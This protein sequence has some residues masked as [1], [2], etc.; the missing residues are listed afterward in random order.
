M[1]KIVALIAALLLCTGLAVVATSAA[2]PAK[3][4]A[5]DSNV[6]SP[7]HL[8]VNGNDLDAHDGEV[9][10][11]PASGLYYLFGTSYGCGFEFGGAGTPYCGV[12]VYSSPD[13]QTW[14]PAG[15]FTPTGQPAGQG[16]SLAFD[17]SGF[18]SECDADHFGCFEAR[19]QWNAANSDWVMWLDGHG[20]LY[21]LTSTAVGGPYAQVTSFAEAPD[22][23]APD[24]LDSEDL[25]T[26]GAKGFLSYTVSALS[27]PPGGPNT[28]QIHVALLN[29]SWTGFDTSYTPTTIPNTFSEAPSLF[30]SPGGT[31]WYM[32]YSNPACPYCNDAGS[33][34]AT[35][36]SVGG[37]PGTWTQQTTPWPVSC[38]AQFDRVDT[39]DNGAL[40]YQSDQWQ[41]LGG[42]FNPNQTLA[43]IYFDSVKGLVP[44]GQIPPQGCD[45]TFNFPLSLPTPN[46]SAT[47][48]V[49]QTVMGAKT[50]PSG[51][52][53]FRGISENMYVRQPGLAGGVT[54]TSN[55]QIVGV[56]MT[57]HTGRYILYGVVNY[58]GLAACSSGFE[59]TAVDDNGA[60]HTETCVRVGSTH[61]FQIKQN[62]ST[63]SALLDGTV[64]YSSALALQT[65][66]YDVAIIDQASYGG[67]SNIFGDPILESEAGNIELMDTT[68]AWASS[69]TAHRSVPADPLNLDAANGTYGSRFADQKYACNTIRA[70]TVSS[71]V[72]P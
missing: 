70:W 39:L 14:T 40:L 18:Q 21:V 11:D 59:A 32:M 28:H 12:G 16:V 37:A 30:R 42:T 17:P 52:D 35:A 1:K 44:D 46:A 3:A 23:V 29:S 24:G 19:P 51:S 54:G 5:P 62:G 15:S 66:P 63:W 36:P 6:P 60:W 13:L 31:T 53:H 25:Y 7:Q 22:T 71:G 68:G 45:G 43:P 57:D 10:I 20:V 27:V 67:D 9:V 4:A 61:Q 50:G 55:N 8:D 64:V 33:S 2:P 56:Q 38:N 49:A 65:S 72:T 41:Q 48:G 26:V 34:Y 69:C 47:H 58:G